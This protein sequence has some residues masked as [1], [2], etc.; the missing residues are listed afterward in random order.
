MAAPWPASGPTLDTRPAQRLFG[1]RR[2]EGARLGR[3]G[4]L[5]A[6]FGKWGRLLPGGKPLWLGVSCPLTR[7]LSSRKVADFLGYRL[8]PP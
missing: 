5:R 4:G 6:G 2:Q 3:R 1:Q 7:G 8:F